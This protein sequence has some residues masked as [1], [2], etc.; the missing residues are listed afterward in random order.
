MMKNYDTSSLPDHCYAVLPSSGRLIE[1]RRGESGYYPCAYSTKDRAYN[2]VLA[3]QFNAHEGITKAQ[4][5]AM[6]TG[7]MFGWDTPGAN[8][9]CYDLDGKPI[10]PNEVKAPPRS[11]Q[12]LYEQARLLRQEYVPGTKVVLDER[13][14]DPLRN[15][16][17][18]LGGIV[19]SVDDTGQIHCH[20]ENGLS[21]PLVPGVDRFHK[22]AVQEADLSAEEI[23]AD[24]EL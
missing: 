4:A 23:E 8:P 13:M 14:D 9:S 15:L 6:L 17:A 10:Q 18:G 5:A 12:Y 11:Y 20:W 21:L 22:E 3:N 2:E 1:I 16:P 24:L 7:S 19:D